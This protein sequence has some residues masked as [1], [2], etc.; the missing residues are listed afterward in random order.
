MSLPDEFPLAHKIGDTFS[1][2]LVVEQRDSDSDPWVAL[3]L[4][5]YVVELSVAQ[6]PGRAGIQ[7]L[8]SDSPARVWVD[9]AENGVVKVLVPASETRAWSR[10]SVYE[11]TLESAGGVRFSILDGPLEVRAE[12]I[13]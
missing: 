10:Y 1:R 3:D 13:A 11:V 12:V 4:T 5:G 8:S 2:E 7:Y 6:A 9:D